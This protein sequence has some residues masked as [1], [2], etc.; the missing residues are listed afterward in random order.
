[1]LDIEA[2]IKCHRLYVRPLKR[3]PIDDG[4]VV[5]KF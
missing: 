2:Y 5:I 3:G 1:M 4:T